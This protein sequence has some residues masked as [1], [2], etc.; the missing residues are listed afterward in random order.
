LNIQSNETSV[1]TTG[2]HLSKEFAKVTSTR[3]APAISSEFEQNSEPHVVDCS[4]TRR[5][6]MKK[7]SKFHCC[8]DKSLHRTPRALTSTRS[9]KYRSAL[10]GPGNL[11]RTQITGSKTDH[12]YN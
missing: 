1:R 10:A 6:D 4:C 11:C 2:R 9:V 7:R 12:Q 8:G 3:D 5:R